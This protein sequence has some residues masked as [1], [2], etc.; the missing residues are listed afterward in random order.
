MKAAG[1]CPHGNFPS[2][3]PLCAEERNK[4]KTEEEPKPLQFQE[5]DPFDDFLEHIDQQ[6]SRREPTERER[7]KMDK[8]LSALGQLF[9]GTGIR[10]QLDGALNISLMRGEY[11]GIHKDLDVSIEADEMTLLEKK[12]GERGYGLFLSYL[13]DPEQP[14]GKKVM[15]RVSAAMFLDAA[16]KDHGRHPMIAAV[17]AKGLIREVGDLNFI[18]THVVRRV[19]GDPIGWHGVRL[20]QDWYEPVSTPFQGTELLLSKPAKV[21]YF[22]LHGTRSYDKT[23]LKLLAESGKMTAT[24]VEQVAT[25]MTAEQEARLKRAEGIFDGIFARFEPTM[26]KDQIKQVFANDSVVGARLKEMS[27]QLDELSE[28]IVT[29]GKRTFGELQTDIVRIFQLDATI[30]KEQQQLDELRS[31]VKSATLATE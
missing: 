25:V 7:E 16:E 12:L 18:D 10:W 26:D 30:A 11:I 22:K 5:R 20:P 14:R 15:E 24:D 17:D 23:D 9:E 31:W 28:L 13:K 4:E 27:A 29:S 1:M 2:S 19:D 3:C 21:A 6:G 8:S